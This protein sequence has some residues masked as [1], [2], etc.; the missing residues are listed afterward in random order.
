MTEFK[1]AP[2]R[3]AE[4]WRL[5]KAEVEAFEP[6]RQGQEAY[7]CHAIRVVRGKMLITTKE[8]G[9]AHR[10]IHSL[11]GDA[12]TLGTWVRRHTGETYDQLRRVDPH[13]RNTR[14]AWLDWL[15]AQAEA[16][17]DTKA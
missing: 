16:R 3:E 11:L 1:V 13:L 5:V 14:L 7:V 10:K 8:A 17:D 15:I 4:I 12:Y 6:A 2:A 9:A